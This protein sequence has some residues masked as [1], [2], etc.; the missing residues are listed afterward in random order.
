MDG[1]PDV[2]AQPAASAGPFAQGGYASRRVRLLEPSPQRSPEVDAALRVQLAHALIIDA[3]HGWPAEHRLDARALKAFELFHT[4]PAQALRY[5]NVA[6]YMAVA[7]AET[8]GWCINDARELTPTCKDPEHFARYWMFGF[9]P[10]T[11]SVTAALESS[12]IVLFALQVAPATA[13]VFGLTLLY[14]SR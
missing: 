6:A 1:Q 9:T 10:L 4:R 14:S 7:F 8:P 3:Y 11:P 13:P 2:A 12:C 5:L